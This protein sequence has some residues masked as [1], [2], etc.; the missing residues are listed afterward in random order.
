MPLIQD[1][2]HIYLITL[3]HNKKGVRKMNV[4]RYRNPNTN[5]GL[6]PQKPVII[7]RIADEPP[8][9][10]RLGDS[11]VLNT[12]TQRLR[13][14]IVLEVSG[15]EG[16]S[17]YLKTRTSKKKYLLVVSLVIC[18]VLLA[19]LTILL[20]GYFNKTKAGNS[21]TTAHA[22][23]V[24]DLNNPNYTIVASPTS[25]NKG[26]FSKALETYAFFDTLDGKKIQVTEQPQMKKYSTIQAEVND[27]ANTAGATTHF[28]TSGSISYLKTDLTSG[29]QIVFA[30]V[31]G[32][33]ITVISVDTHSI[34]SWTSYISSLK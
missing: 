30:P 18:V 3:T 15:Q 10:K 27:L 9:S 25:G 22:K 17:T 29:Y 11:S 14:D 26:T 5:R 12:A 31:N 34:G 6:I 21:A 4:N 24:I 19:G 8:L 7:P 33:L 32:L 28:Q 13:E 23:T 16:N 20:M 1:S 2:I